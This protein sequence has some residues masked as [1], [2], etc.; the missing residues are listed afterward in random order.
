MGR[1]PAVKKEG[2]ATDLIA[3]RAAA[4]IQ[5]SGDKPFFMYLPFNAVHWPFQPPKR[6]NDVRDERTWLDGNG[7]DYKL[8]LEGLDSAIGRVLTA[9][10][11]KS[12]ANNTIVVFTNDNGGERFSNNGGLFHHKGTTLGRR[13]PRARDRA[14][15]GP[16]TSRRDLESANRDV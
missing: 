15:A 1:N 13:Y 3:D 14:L 10:D 11:K 9:L 4:Y 7:Q 2:Y 16:A 5:K 12:I 6:P 8:M